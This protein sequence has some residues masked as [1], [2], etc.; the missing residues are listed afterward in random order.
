LE[1]NLEYR[2]DTLD[3]TYADIKDE[4]DREVVQSIANK[5]LPL[6]DRIEIYPI[7]AEQPYFLAF[8]NGEHDLTQE[9]PSTYLQ[10]IFPNGKLA[11]GLA[12]QGVRAFRELQAELTYDAFNM[13][14]PVVG[15]YDPQHVALRR[16]ISMG[17]NRNQEITVIRRNTPL[18]AQSAVPPGVVGYDPSFTAV[19]QDYDP[20]RAKALLDTF[21]YVDR[22]GDGYREQPDG[23]PLTIEYK[24]Q[25]GSLASRQS[26]EL[27]LKSMTALG[28][29]MR[30]T[31]VQFADLI[32]DQKVG[33]FQM[34]GAAWLADYPDAQ[35]FLQL[36]YGPNKGASNSARFDL[37]QFNKL[38]EQALT[39]PDSPERN[40]LYREMNRYVLAYVPWHLGVTRSWVHV[41]RPWVKGYKKHPMYHARYKYL[42]IDVAA[43][44]AAQR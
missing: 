28:I 23:S 35:N 24:V 36:L 34:S 21:G 19:D 42:D 25:S 27:W 38:Y 14:D 30:I 11:P 18:A 8:M 13:E 2:S 44:Q 4:W 16:A 6:L 26:A 39:I 43:Q 41:M 31:G 5:K 33:K 17:Y 10:Q 22:D 3:A 15:G 7:E 37:P 9:L 20:I 29:R 32:R 40:A 1:K 12:K